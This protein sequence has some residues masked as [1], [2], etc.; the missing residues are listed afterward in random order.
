MGSN[1]STPGAAERSIDRTVTAVILVAAT[2]LI[3]RLYDLGRRTFH[4]DEA[5]IGYWIQRYYETGTWHYRPILHGSFL[6]HVNRWTFELLGPGDFAA[7]LPVAVV[8]AAL[9]L[10][11]LLFRDR[12]R[13]D[14]TVALALLLAFTPLLLYYS[15]FMRYDVPLA[16]FGLLALGF[17]L[18]AWDR[19]D[20]RHL[21]PAA[22]SLG[23]AFTTKESVLLYPVAWTGA[24]VLTG[25]ILTR[26]SPP[27]LSRL[28]PDAE[29]RIIDRLDAWGDHVPVAAVTFLAVTTFFYAPRAGRYGDVGLYRTLTHPGDFSR[30]L[31]EATAV[32]VVKA[33]AFWVAGGMQNHPYIPYLQDYL[34]TLGE[35]APWLLLLGALGLVTDRYLDRKRRPL[36]A[37]FTL[38]ALLFVIGYPKANFLPTPWSVVHAAVPLALPA[39][40]GL[41]WLYRVAREGSGRRLSGTSIFA[42]ALLIIVAVTTAATTAQVSYVAPHDGSHEIVYSS[43]SHDLKPVLSEVEAAIGGND[44][45]DVLFYGDYYALDHESIADRPHHPPAYGDW[46]GRIPLPWY[47][48]TMNAT[49]GS[50]REPAA[51]ERAAPPVIIVLAPEDDLPP[52]IKEG[53]VRHVADL[54]QLDK[55]THFYIR[56]DLQPGA[57]GE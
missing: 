22:A 19:R 34:A 24:A 3:A 25:L 9:P 43:Q 37:F 55:T 11:A 23:L 46:H 42:I 54:D 17:G 29:N 21:Y 18:R 14:E 49:T 45:V 6:P 47:L 30:L 32:P 36:V 1:R 50:A 5:W 20:P 53:Y 10:A 28:V 35:G 33:L 57:G 41:A 38:L 7:R 56:K 31:L 16:A 4:Y 52:S 44:G 8:G 51:V 39:A 12:L 27:A 26:A 15:R 40:V 48:Q 2:A 13:D